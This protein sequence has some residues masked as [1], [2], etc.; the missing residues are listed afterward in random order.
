MKGLNIL[1]VAAW[2]IFANLGVAF[3]LSAPWLAIIALVV[4]GSWFV[5]LQN[6][7]FALFIGCVLI[8]AASVIGG[9]C[10]AVG[11]HRFCLLGERPSQVLYFPPRALIWNYIGACIK[12]ILVAIL[13][14]LVISLVVGFLAMILLPIFAPSDGTAGSLGIFAL[15]P[16]LLV[17]PISVF[18]A[19]L[20]LIL[21]AA[22]LNKTFTVGD[23]ISAT[24]AN[25]WTLLVLVIAYTV[26]GFVYDLM[27]ANLG[28]LQTPGLFDLGY[29]VA[30][31]FLVFS[32]WFFFMYGIGYVSELFGTLVLDEEEPVLA[33]PSL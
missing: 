26:L 27:V 3:R 4:L 22:A 11:W 32:N 15:I 24:I 8:F 28:L 29:I 9:T 13:I 17:A 18:V 20:A 1:Y 25:F 30:L 12:Y 16:L 10:V 19:G 5:F 33:E 31:L 23:A 2:R 7:G 14:G 21:P 6:G